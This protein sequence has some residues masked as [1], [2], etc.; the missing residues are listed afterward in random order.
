MQEDLLQKYLY[1]AYAKLRIIYIIA[2]FKTKSKTPCNELIKIEKLES[3]S[4]SDFDTS[5]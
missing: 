5:Q 1:T 4:E 3:S 2:K